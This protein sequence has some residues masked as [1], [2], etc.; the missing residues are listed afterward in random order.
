MFPSYT[1]KLV[2]YNLPKTLGATRNNFKA[3]P[4][5]IRVNSHLEMSRGSADASTGRTITLTSMGPRQAPVNMVADKW[6]R[7]TLRG[8]G[9]VH[10]LRR[11]A[12]VDVGAGGV[13]GW[14]NCRRP[15]RRPPQ[16]DQKLSNNR[17]QWVVH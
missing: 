4:P 3:R 7:A 2:Q 8:R 17:G 12:T 10:W 9:I 11:F 13:F 6:R 14:S 1:V 16:S 5:G 15:A